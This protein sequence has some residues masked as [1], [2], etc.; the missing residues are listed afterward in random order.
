MG[1]GLLL[2]LGSVLLLA[3]IGLWTADATHMIPSHVDDQWSTLTLRS[4]AVLLAAAL[5]LRL[6]SPVTRQIGRGRCAICGAS[7]ERGHMYCRDHLQE[8]V[9]AVRDQTRGRLPSSSKRRA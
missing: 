3:T 2:T 4:G 8:T 1:R 5:L 6:V 7:T 9:H